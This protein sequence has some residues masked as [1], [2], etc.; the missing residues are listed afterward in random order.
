MYG[1][2]TELILNLVSCHFRVFTFVS[3][4][5]RIFLPYAEECL[6]CSV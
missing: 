1:Y 5:F 2:V 3:M 6:I 4:N